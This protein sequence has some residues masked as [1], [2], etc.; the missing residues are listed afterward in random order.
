MSALSDGDRGGSH[1]WGYYTTP[2]GDC[3][4]CAD[5]HYCWLCAQYGRDHESQCD[6]SKPE[7]ASR[8]A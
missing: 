4:Y 3:S 8:A 7:P 1:D 5:R 6:F 2:D